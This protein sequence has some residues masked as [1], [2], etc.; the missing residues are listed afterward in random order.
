MPKVHIIKSIEIKFALS[1][2]VLILMA[3]NLK[4]I[5]RIQF[6]HLSIQVPY[7]RV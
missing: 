6:P 4:S 5:G 2:K 3:F 7:I 1:L